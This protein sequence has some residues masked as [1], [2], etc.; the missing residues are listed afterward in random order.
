MRMPSQE[1]HQAELAAAEEQRRLD[2]EMEIE[3]LRALA[4]YQVG[5]GDADSG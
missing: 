1:Q 3:R 2:A 4:A 5:H